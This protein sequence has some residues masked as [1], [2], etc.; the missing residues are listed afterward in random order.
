MPRSHQSTTVL[1]IS[2][3]KR[4]LFIVLIVGT[5]LLAGLTI[6]EVFLRYRQRQIKQSKVM[7]DN[8][9]LYNRLLGWELSRN[10]Q[11]RHREFDYDVIY[12]TN[13][14][15]YRGRFTF[16]SPNESKRYAVLGDS[17][18]FGFGV[19][20]EDTFVRLLNDKFKSN[21]IFFNFAT[22]GYSTDQEYILLRDGVAK[23]TP[24]AVIL[25]VYLGN[26]LFDN[27]LKFP[28]QSDLAKPYFEIAND[29]LRLKNTPVPRERKSQAQQ[30]HDNE[31]MAFLNDRSPI[32]P[33]FQVLSRFHLLQ[34]AR[35]QF[36]TF[37]DL[38]SEFATRYVHTLRLF[39]ALIAEI[40]T[41]CDK[42]QSELVVVLLPGK[43]FIEQP[44][45]PAAQSQEYL[46]KRIVSELRGDNMQVIDLA[47]SLR[48]RF[49]QQPGEWYFPHDGHLTIPG[50]QVV[51]ELLVRELQ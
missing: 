18:T 38:R 30:Q 15:G 25:I 42:G 4:L 14:H 36:S 28:L 50:H 39:L 33:P 40:N 26:D 43:S 29:S 5:I 16:Q 1:D 22:P 9:F 34:M 27:E 48:A 45:T 7:D 13:Q 8:L 23:Y 41:E 19:N 6:G 37:P 24:D 32:P 49:E 12:S 20:D 46:R 47:S 10:W 17:F 51:A 44:E 31:R 35:R 3:R 11:G 2:K 21:K